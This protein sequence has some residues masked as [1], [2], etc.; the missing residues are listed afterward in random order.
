LKVTLEENPAYEILSA[1]SI[2]IGEVD[3]DDFESEE[4]AIIP[5]SN[6]PQLFFTLEYRD[7]N[8]KEFKETKRINL[9]IYTEEE[10]RQLGLVKDNFNW[11]FAALILVNI[12]LIYLYIRKKKNVN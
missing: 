2:Y 11:I 9:N 10:A 6:N 5:N 12:I 4:F 1:N 3:I 7:F 8:N